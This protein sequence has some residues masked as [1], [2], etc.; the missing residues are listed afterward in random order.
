MGWE[1]TPCRPK[2]TCLSNSAIDWATSMTS[3]P[4]VV[5]APRA[6]HG[7]RSLPIQKWIRTAWALQAEGVRTIAIDRDKEVLDAF[8][9]FAYGY[10]WHHLLALMS[11]STVV[12]GNDSG[13]PHLSATIGRPTVAAMGPTV[14]SI[15]FGHCTDVVRVVGQREVDCFGCHFLYD[16]GYRVAC[17]RG[18]EALSMVSWK[19][20]KAEIERALADTSVIPMR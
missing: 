12:A 14:D 2:L 4:S 15:I 19:L 1:F 18:C 5:I 6:A 8:P 3:E 11:L 16:K 9:F 20:L 13:I 10:D 7:A 17:D